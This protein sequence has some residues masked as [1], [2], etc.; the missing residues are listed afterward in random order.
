MSQFSFTLYSSKFCTYALVWVSS[1]INNLL[2]LCQDP[3]ELQRLRSNGNQPELRSLTSSPQL[4]EC[5]AAESI[6]GE[7]QLFGNTTWNMLAA[8]QG[9][10][11]W[12]GGVAGGVSGITCL[13]PWTSTSPPFDWSPS[14][15]LTFLPAAM[16]QRP[17]LLYTLVLSHS[18]VQLF[19]PLISLFPFQPWDQ[20]LGRPKNGG[21]VLE[22]KG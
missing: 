16:C 4:S 6:A 9:T 20:V 21:D 12:G 19:L 8:C 5:P 2:Y 14:L 11:S 1:P 7:W 22:K 10:L 3:S 13:F 17:S 15:V 18:C